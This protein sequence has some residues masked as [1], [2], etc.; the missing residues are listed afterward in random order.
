[1]DLRCVI[2]S[3]ND[4]LYETHGHSLHF[5]N[6][7]LLFFAYLSCQTL[8]RLNKNFKYFDCPVG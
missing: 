7:Y 6:L 2:L 8:K 4:F 1:M 3:P 5:E